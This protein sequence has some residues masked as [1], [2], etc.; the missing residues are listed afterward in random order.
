[1]PTPG[2]SLLRGADW[3]EQ[4]SSCFMFPLSRPRS[5]TLELTSEHKG[6]RFSYSP[7]RIK[8]VL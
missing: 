8:E 3:R 6:V 7:E 1:M 2:T 4:L 5:E